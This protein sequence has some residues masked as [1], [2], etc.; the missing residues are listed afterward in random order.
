MNRVVVVLI[1]SVLGL[2]A[3]FALLAR[4]NVPDTSANAVSGD[5]ITLFCAASNRSVMEP[6]LDDYRKE[7]GAKLLSNTVLPK[8]C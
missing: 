5:P 8:H 6:I 7:F 2:A 3:M 4:S 1:G